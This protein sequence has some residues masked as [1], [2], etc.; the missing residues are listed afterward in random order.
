MPRH[1]L[2]QQHD[3]GVLM[4]TNSQHGIIS[5]EHAVHEELR[6]HVVSDKIESRIRVE[7]RVPRGSST[8]VHEEAIN[9]IVGLREK[10]L[11]RVPQPHH[12]GVLEERVAARRHYTVDGRDLEPP[13][14]AARDGSY[15]CLLYTSDAADE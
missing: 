4:R 8:V 1:V 11:D 13:A 5:H 6:P 9:L 10:V 14:G 15:A 7:R 2:Q 3:Q 12:V